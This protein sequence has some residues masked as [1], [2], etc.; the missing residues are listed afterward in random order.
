MKYF[1][2]TREKKTIDETGKCLLLSLQLFSTSNDI[3]I[4]YADLRHPSEQ[5]DFA[6]LEEDTS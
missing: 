3:I 5:E 1:L 2:P 6:T 4:T